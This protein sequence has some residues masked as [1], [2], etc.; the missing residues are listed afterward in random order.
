MK[1]RIKAFILCIS[2]AAT[3]LASSCGRAAPLTAADY[4]SLGER[5]LL[6]LDYEQAV[7]HFQR[8]IEIDPMNPR[9]YTGLAQAFAKL[10]KADEAIAALKQGYSVLP[11]N[12]EFLEQSVDVYE[13]IIEI[14]P[15]NPDGYTGLA[16]SL[17][18]LERDDEAI[19]VLQKGAET[20]TG[21]RGFH[22]RA[23][24]IINGILEK[25]PDNA[26]AYIGLFEALA[27]LGNMER[28]RE[29]LI[30][31][32]DRIKNHEKLNALYESVFASVNVP[33][34]PNPSPSPSPSPLPPSPPSSPPPGPPT[35]TPTTPPTTT[36][37]TPTTTPTTPT[38]TP[39]TPTTPTT[40]PATPPTTTTPTP[41]APTISIGS[42]WY[43]IDEGGAYF[44]LKYSVTGTAPV[45]VTMLVVD[46]DG[47]AAAGFS[48]NPT[49]KNLTVSTSVPAGLYR[50]TLTAANT[51]GS[52]SADIY[53]EVT[54]KTP[55]VSAPVI[56]SGTSSYSIMEGGG[57]I[58]LDYTLTGTEPITISS[59]V[60]SIDGRPASGFSV[61][62]ASRTVSVGAGVSAGTYL[63]TLTATNSAGSDS[64]DFF[65]EVMSN[66][67]VITPPTFNIG[68]TNYS[69]IAGGGVLNLEYTLKG[70]EPIM[71]SLEVFDASGM[72]ASGF[73]LGKNNNTILVGSGVLPGDYYLVLTANN[74]GG[75]STATFNVSVENKLH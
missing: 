69:I 26:D 70:H 12:K 55:A 15:E 43:S 28:A 48:L 35:T 30:Q 46:A 32:H 73:T 52:V 67:T 21:N 25:N 37:T 22:E 41:T 11:D 62:G 74:D 5:Y 40:T 16:E 54:A 34:S 27:A 1:P 18:G 2:V 45:T 4:L 66:I 9:G 63:V 57:T 17:V 23:S 65:I 13:E 75:V 53:I 50:G 56:N 58:S 24:T 42:G 64:T 72:L 29:I 36:P 31:G 39:P 14:A 38:T 19:A 49:S 59:Q 71:V 68:K 47:R 51:A 6:E 10:N 33:A 3:L 7:I 20:I 8:L 44:L 60:V 61:S